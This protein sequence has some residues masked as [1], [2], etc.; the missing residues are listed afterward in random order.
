MAYVSRKT[1]QNVIEDA[2]NLKNEKIESD[3]ILRFGTG[4]YCLSTYGCIDEMAKIM[5]C[6]LLLDGDYIRD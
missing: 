6:S 5:V 4:F 2:G 1:I 3:E